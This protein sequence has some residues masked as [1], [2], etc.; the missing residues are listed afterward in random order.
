MSGS[1]PLSSL[2]ND[3]EVRGVQTSG[4]FGRGNGAKGGG[5]GG[6]GVSVFSTTKIT[7]THRH[8]HQAGTEQT[9]AGAEE[10]NF[11]DLRQ[12]SFPPPS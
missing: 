3:K 5:W 6:G 1:L 11:I 12:V 10:T 9:K 4:G 8:G 7:S 2:R